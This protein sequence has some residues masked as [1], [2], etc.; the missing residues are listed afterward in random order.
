MALPSTFQSRT[1]ATF[2]TNGLLYEQSNYDPT[3]YVTGSV[4]QDTGF[5][6]KVNRQ[7][8]S[9]NSRKGVGL[10]LSQFIL[11][12]ATDK[13]DIQM[14]LSFNYRTGSTITD[15]YAK[16]RLI[17]ALDFLINNYDELLSA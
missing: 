6:V 5:T 1:S 9:N 13:Q 11:A 17:E 15:A 12:S 2:A 8:G 16:A 14:S 7:S 4:S 3:T 10:K